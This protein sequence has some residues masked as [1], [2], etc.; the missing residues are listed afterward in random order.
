M[1]P[2]EFRRRGKEVIDFVADYIENIRTRPV[3]PAVEPGYLQHMLPDHAPETPDK[4]EDIIKDI[5]RVIMPGM[6]HWQ[7]PHFHAY[8]KVACSFPSICADII[9][10][11]FGSPVFSW[12]SC[13]AGTELEMVTTDWLGKALG[14]PTE[15]LFCS[16]GKGGGIIQ[17]SA[18][19]ATLI[20]VF[21]AKVKMMK[22]QKS[23]HPDWSDIYILGKLVMYSSEH[24]HSSVEKASILESVK[25]R[26]LPGDNKFSLRGSALRKA[27]E[28]DAENGYIPF[29][30]VATLGT[31]NSCAFDNLQEVGEVCKQNEVWLHVDAAYAGAAFVC[32]EFRYLMKGVELVD[33][34]DFNPHKWLLVNYEC[35]VMWFRDS[36]AVRNG[37]RV[38]PM[39]LKHDYEGVVPDYR[40]WQIP[41]GRRFRSMKLWFVLRMYGISGLQEHIRKFVRLAHEVESMMLKDDRFEIIGDVIMG[42]IC[43]RLKGSNELNKTLLKNI[44]DGRR[45]YLVPAEINDSYFLRFSIG[46][47]DPNSNDMALS[48]K[49]IQSHTDCLVSREV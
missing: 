18:S 43:F 31:T 19:E 15:F 41:L 17:G 38:D 21:A 8:F 10:E 14:L 49:E 35:S 6:T 37:F 36:D 29:C 9:S 32:P 27:I 33:S 20:A 4:W 23:I 45:I 25:I 48:W 16:N 11:A 39:Y 28:D 1:D 47:Y 42:L 26:L 22:I 13:P 7:S 24:A 40:N 5:E 12:Q 2:S 3:L 44:N 34:F 30:V 46:G